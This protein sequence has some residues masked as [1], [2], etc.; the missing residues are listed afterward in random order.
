MA[1]ETKRRSSKTKTAKRRTS[2]KRTAG[3]RKKKGTFKKDLIIFFSVVMLVSVAAFGYFLG[4]NNLRSDKRVSNTYSAAVQDENRVLLENLEKI[5]RENALKEKRERDKKREEEKKRKQKQAEQALPEKQKDLPQSEAVNLTVPFGPT[6]VSKEEKVWPK[7]EKPK[8][9]I[10][11]DD[12]SS[13]AQLEKIKSLGLHLTPSIFPP[14]RFAPSSHTLAE[15]LKHYMAHLPMQSGKSF[16]KQEKTLM[17]TDSQEVIAA[18][19][20]EIRNFFPAARFVNNHT[21]SV[22]TGN[23]PA[24]DTLY[25]ALQKEGFVFVDSRTTGSTKVP[26]IAKKHGD[27]YFARDVFIDNQHTIASIHKQLKHAVKVAKKRG[28]A[29]AIGHPHLATLKALA[30]ASDILKEVEMVY[31]DELYQLKVER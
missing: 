4:K 25:R 2:A 23:Y 29:I 26:Q 13:R 7:N 12:V 8:L 9:V 6:G 21:G 15:G 20:G 19:I 11:I 10:I 16:D 31:M 22:F 24:M 28:Y 18:R 3:R 5:K 30:S 17:I 1:K 14:Y 27:P